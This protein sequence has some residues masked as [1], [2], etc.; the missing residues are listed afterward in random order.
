MIDVRG[1]NPVELDRTLHMDNTIDR[2]RME[3]NS[4]TARRF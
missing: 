4:I 3:T 2:G 1:Y